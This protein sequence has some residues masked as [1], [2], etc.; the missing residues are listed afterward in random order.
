MS[1][2]SIVT[3]GDRIRESKDISGLS[4]GS[5]LEGQKVITARLNTISLSSPST[6]ARHTVPGET[7][8]SLKIDPI[9]DWQ[10][11]TLYRDQFYLDT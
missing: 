1:I 7:V 11:T 3:S 9:Q 2:N 8:T 4:L 6:L 10:S 5:G